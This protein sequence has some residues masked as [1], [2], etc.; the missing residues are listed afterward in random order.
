MMYLD[1]FNMM[2]PPKVSSLIRAGRAPTAPAPA[3]DNR[4][5]AGQVTCDFLE[6]SLVHPNVEPD[7]SR[8]VAAA[9]GGDESAFRALV[10]LHYD[11]CLRYAMR[12]L[13]DR[14]E[15]EDVVQEVFVRVH[16]GLRSYQEQGRFKGWVFRILVNQCRSA[17]V[18]RAARQSVLI[19]VDDTPEH[20]LATATIETEVAKS[21]TVHRALSAL[22]E[23]LREAFVLKFVEEWSYEEMA[24]LTGARES[25]LKMRVA[26]AKDLLRERL[27]GLNDAR[28]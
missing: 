23:L 8:A 26:R 28:T 27:Q 17:A 14:S 1:L 24:E 11:G 12:M 16:R 18:S 4:Q 22:P 6:R 7:E 9:V 10:E 20:E 3:N 5:S 2:P 25:A 21:D 13:G 15:A 19:S